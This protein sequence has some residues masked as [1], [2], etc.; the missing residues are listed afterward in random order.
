MFSAALH[1]SLSDPF[2]PF[3]VVINSTA[4]GGEADIA[5]TSQIGRS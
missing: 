5:Q 1:M 3:A 2:R 4:V